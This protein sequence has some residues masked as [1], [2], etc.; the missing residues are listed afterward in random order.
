MAR[1]PFALWWDA[2]SASY[3]LM[4]RS[5]ELATAST[6][7]IAHR[8]GTI[9]TAMHD[10]AA[11]DHSELLGMV[12][13]KVEAFAHANISLLQDLGQANVDL[14]ALAA[15]FGSM[16]PAALATESVKAGTRASRSAERALRPIHRRATANARRLGRKKHRAG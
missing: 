13:E 11:A 16:T 14:L 9:R 8:S 15:R 5:A 10:P 6:Q 4:M 3:N 1:S 12:T 7:V 2:A